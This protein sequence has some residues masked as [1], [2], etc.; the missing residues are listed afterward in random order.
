LVTSVPKPGEEGETVSIGGTIF[1][2]VTQEDAEKAF[3]NNGSGYA[4][5][6]SV[7]KIRVFLDIGE[8]GSVQTVKALSGDEADKEA[9][10]QVAKQWKFKPYVKNG[11]NVAVQMVIQLD[12]KTEKMVQK[13]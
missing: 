6:K 4:Y 3:A 13:R 7:G 10:K 5:F 2:V 12:G 11:K 1:P 8:D 9:A